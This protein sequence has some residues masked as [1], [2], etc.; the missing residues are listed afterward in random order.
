MLKFALDKDRVQANILL[1]RQVQ[2]RTRLPKSPRSPTIHLNGVPAACIFEAPSRA[3]LVLPASFQRRQSSRKAQNVPKRH[4]IEDALAPSTK[5]SHESE[6][7]VLQFSPRGLATFISPLSKLQDQFMNMSKAVKSTANVADGLPSKELPYPPVSRTSIEYKSW[8]HRPHTPYTPRDAKGEYPDSNELAGWIKCRGKSKSTIL[9]PRD[10]KGE[11]PALH[12]QIDLFRHAP[13][14]QRDTMIQT[15]YH[16]GEISSNGPSSHGESDEA[17]EDVTTPHTSEAESEG[18]ALDPL[19][20]APQRS[21]GT[22]R[23]ASRIRS[24]TSLDRLGL[25]RSPVATT[26]KK[27]K[28]VLKGTTLELLQPTVFK[29]PTAKAETNIHFNDSSSS[30]QT[31]SSSQNSSATNVSSSNSYYRSPQY[32][33]RK[34]RCRKETLRAL[35]RQLTVTPQHGNLM[36]KASTSDKPLPDLPPDPGGGSQGKISPMS[37]SSVATEKFFDMVRY[38]NRS[39]RQHERWHP[40]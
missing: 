18:R 12:W 40:D 8:H 5:G 11:F 14:S 36:M 33:A 16:Y 2:F 34:D 4:S 1:S 6:S 17:H 31:I 32:A 25:R 20:T 39:N 15:A 13:K 23:F 7:T 3:K 37:L 19:N 26:C 9:T 27:P 38:L 28:L 21:L 24:R 22:S 10:A 35:E 29:P 30:S